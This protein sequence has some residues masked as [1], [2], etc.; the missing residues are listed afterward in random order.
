MLSGAKAFNQPIGSWDVSKVTDMN[1]MFWEAEAFIRNNRQKPNVE[2]SIKRNLWR[3][4]RLV[5]EKGETKGGKPL[6]PAAK[7][8]IAYAIFKFLIKWDDNDSSSSGE[9]SSD[10]RWLFIWRIYRIYGEGQNMLECSFPMKWTCLT[11]RAWRERESAGQRGQDRWPQ[12]VGSSTRP[13][14]LS[15]PLCDFIPAHSVEA[16]YNWYHCV[17]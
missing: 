13:C 12:F 10:V 17:H 3:N 7:R 14:L 15:Y 11:S 2:R 6:V 1:G 16:V 9:T 5:T 4:A 8:D